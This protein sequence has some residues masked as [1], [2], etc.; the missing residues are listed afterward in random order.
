MKGN[1]VSQR[2]VAHANGGER[3]LPECSPEAATAKPAK[4]TRR[5]GGVLGVGV[6]VWGE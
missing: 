1:E 3:D 4:D 2:V 6:L 5:L